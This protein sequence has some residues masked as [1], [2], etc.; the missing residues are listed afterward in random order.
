MCKDRKQS[1]KQNY[2]LK[3]RVSFKRA[4]FTVNNNFFLKLK[5]NQG[6]IWI[7]IVYICFIL[8]HTGIFYIRFK[9]RQQNSSGQTSPRPTSIISWTIKLVSNPPTTMSFSDVDVH[10]TAYL[11]ALNNIS[12]RIFGR[13]IGMQALILDIRQPDI[14]MLYVEYIELILDRCARKE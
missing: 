11:K 3:H 1:Q 8:S 2:F 10:C 4:Q 7:K 6:E 14:S 13:M 9:P 5:V 12:C